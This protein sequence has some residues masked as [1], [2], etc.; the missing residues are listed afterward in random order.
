MESDGWHVAALGVL[1]CFRES[2][3]CVRLWV[4]HRTTHGVDM[5][6]V[7]KDQDQSME[8]ILQSIKRI[9]AEE[10]DA[11]PPPP[12]A[13]DVLDLTAMVADDGTVASAGGAAEM[14]IDE[15]MAAP[16]A[17]MMDTT[18]PAPPEPEFTPPPAALEPEFTAP[19]A[20]PEPAML[21]EPDSE[22]VMTAAAHTPAAISAPATD[23]DSL[24]SEVTRMAS[25]AALSALHEAAPLSALATPAPAH[26]GFRSGSTVEDLVLE[27]LRPMLRE[28][29]DSHLPSIVERLVEREIRKISRS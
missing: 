3:V 23:A 8:D 29:I 11:V 20:A 13:D 22:P 1:F 28:W 9:I 24:M 17:S 4:R 7:A 25:V 14:S 19:P 15:I 21:E 18:P 2:H 12:A 16:M 6:E 10:G 26:I 27:S 5:A